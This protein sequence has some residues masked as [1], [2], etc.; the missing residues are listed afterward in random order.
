MDE[1]P[2]VLLGLRTKDQGRP[3]HLGTSSAEM[4]YGS[5]L[6]VPGAFISPPPAQRSIQPDTCDSY[7]TGSELWPEYR[8]PSMASS[9]ASLLSLPPSP[10]HRLSSCTAM[11]RRSPYILKAPISRDAPVPP[12]ISRFERA[13][14]MHRSPPT[15]KAAKR[16][17]EGIGC[18]IRGH[19]ISIAVAA[20]TQ[21]FG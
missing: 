21:I 1:L 9:S 3:G 20:R 14:A 18:G 17:L 5:P 10:R 4:V 19:Y 15:F 7:E 16:E 11:G 13:K 8:Q 12:I 6:A 2:W